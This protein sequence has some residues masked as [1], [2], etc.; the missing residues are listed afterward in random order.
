MASSKDLKTAHSEFKQ[1]TDAIK[2]S[3]SSLDNSTVK[4]SSLTINSD[5]IVMKAGK[6]TTDVANAIGSYFAVNQNAINLFSDKINVK[7][8]M[9]VNGAIT[10]DKIQAN[11]VDVSKISGLD[12]NFIKSKVEYAMIDWLKGKTIVA[13]NGATKIDLLS[14]HINFDS[15]EP[16]IRRVTP[17]IPTQFIKFLKSDNNSVTTIGSNRDGSESSMND[18]FAGIKILSSNAIE[19]TEIISDQICF[20][21]GSN[22]RRGWQMSTISG[23]DSR[24]IK[25]FPTGNVSKSNIYASDYFIKRS[26]GLVNLND[27][28]NYINTCLGH[29][30][31]YTGRTDI[32]NPFEF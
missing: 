7:G 13:D 24:E 14:G 21:T 3:V 25:L 11:S 30:Q 20:L 28:I 2:A 6:S 18:S 4:S 23:A 32:W 27:F 19:Q 22:I 17:G 1:T 26:K 15:N 5:G 12:A 29:L 10:G 16:A 9:I 8:N 31:N